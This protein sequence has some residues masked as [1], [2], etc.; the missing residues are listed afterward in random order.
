MVNDETRDTGKFDA[1]FLDRSR[2]FI[3]HRP[4]IILPTILF[5]FS[6]PFS[7]RTPTV[8]ELFSG[9]PTSFP[10]FLERNLS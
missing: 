3:R 7:F 10:R 4:V 6:P 9:S 8:G 5:F 1:R 2:I